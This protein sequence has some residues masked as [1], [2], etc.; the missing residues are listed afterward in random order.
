MLRTDLYNTS[1][2]RSWSSARHWWTT[3]T[4]RSSRHWTESTF[5]LGNTSAAHTAATRQ[6]FFTSTQSEI[7]DHDLLV[8]RVNDKLFGARRLRF[9]IGLEASRS[10]AEL[11]LHAPSALLCLNTATAGGFANAGILKRDG[12]VRAELWLDGTEC[13][14]Q[15]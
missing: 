11:R 14:D 4:G 12:F 6:L 8:V 5:L 3:W 2:A 13:T 7:T 10:V 15:H 1:A 9:Q